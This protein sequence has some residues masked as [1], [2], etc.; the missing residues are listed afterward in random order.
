MV[1]RAATPD[2][3]AH[4]AASICIAGISAGILYTADSMSADD[5]AVWRLH[6]H[7]GRRVDVRAVLRM[8]REDE[9]CRHGPH[10]ETD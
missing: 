6:T 4:S 9:S 5:T 3:A 7:D 2:P 8:A 1:R 10:A